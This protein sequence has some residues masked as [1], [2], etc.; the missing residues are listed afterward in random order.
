MSF[1][2]TLLKVDR[3]KAANALK[4]LKRLPKES[5]NPGIRVYYIANVFG[6]WDNC[7]WFEAK[8]NKHAIEYVQNTLSKIPGIV[9]THTLPTSPVREYYKDWK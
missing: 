5:P 8:N 1:Y 7:V 2:W 6:E 3:T 9:C 4:G